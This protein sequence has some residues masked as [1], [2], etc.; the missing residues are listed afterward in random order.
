MIK[1][2]IFDFDGVIADSHGIIN[3]LFTKIANEKLNLGIA[4]DD[5]AK[6][7]GMRFEHRLKILAKEKNIS[8]DEKE[9]EDIT[10]FGRLEY[11]T[12]NISYV[13]FFP[14][15]KDLLCELK[16]KKMMMAIGTNGSRNNVENILRRFGILD[17]FLSIV[18]YYDV[19]HGKPNP[20]M[21]LK[22]ARELKIMPQECVVIDDAIEGISAGHAAGM[23][24]IAVATTSD[25]K[26][27][28]DAD[29]VVKTIKDI[30]YKLI[31]SLHG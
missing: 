24:V 22:N 23:K 4:E 3:K 1:A 7:P 12:N 11:F 26:E 14:G 9:I 13:S 21:F 6:F 15:V 18:T 29:I 10:K 25:E 17:Y 30:N 2:V 28:K 8:L 16:E 31:Q 20:E 19:E 5:F 27:L